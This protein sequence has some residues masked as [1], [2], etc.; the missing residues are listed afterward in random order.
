M[1]Y[2]ATLIKVFLQYDFRGDEMASITIT[3]TDN[4]TSE[5]FVGRVKW[6][7][8]Q[9]NLEVSLKALE[10]KV[11]DHLKRVGIQAESEEIRQAMMRVFEKG[12]FDVLD[13]TNS[14]HAGGYHDNERKDIFS[15]TF[16]LKS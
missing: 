16:I 4:L 14:S 13:I 11:I 8:L 1:F 10:E 5:D 3:K 7:L 2:Y 6:V 9:S 12:A 15:A